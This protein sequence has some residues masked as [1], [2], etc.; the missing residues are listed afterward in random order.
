[1]TTLWQDVRYGIR[2]LAKRPGF[3]IIAVLALALG[4]GANMAIFSVVNAVILR[5]LPYKDPE[6]IVTI[7]GTAPKLDINVFPVSGPDFVDWRNQNHV[8]EQLAAMEEASFNLTGAGG[9]P[10]RVG[11]RRAVSVVR[12]QREFRAHVPRRRGKSRAQ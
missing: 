7:L 4:I 9:E 10:E 1:M 12:R 2:M 8:F 6:Q 3:T 11:E 5:P